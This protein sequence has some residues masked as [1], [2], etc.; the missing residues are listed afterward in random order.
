[1]AN[2]NVSLPEPLKNWADEQAKSGNFNDA[3]DYVRDLIRKDQ[4]DHAFALWLDKE[5]DVGLARGPS[6][7]SFKEIVSAARADVLAGRDFRC[8]FSRSQ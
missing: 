4:E 8:Q 5:I 6:P 1:M 3:G 7:S 2:M